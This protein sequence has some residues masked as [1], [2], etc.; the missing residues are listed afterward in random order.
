MMGTRG[1]NLWRTISA[2]RPASEQWHE[3]AVHRLDRLTMPH[4]ALGRLMDLAADLA[5]MTETLNPPVARRSIVAFAA[6]H[7]VWSQG[8]APY[9]QIVT[10]QVTR[11]IAG[12]VAS[13]CVLGRQ[14]GAQV[15][16]VDVGVLGDL[17]GIDETHLFRRKIARGT[18]DLS[19][20]P[21][22]TRD[23]AIQSLETG[24]EIGNLLADR[25]DIFGTGEMGVC[26]TTPSSAILSVMLGISPA[27]ATGPGSGLDPAGTAHKAE[28][29][30]RALK[31][32]N[33]DKND[34]IDVL[35]KVGGF[36]I[37]GIAGLILAAACQRKPVLLDGFIAAAA[38]VLAQ[39]LCPVCCDFMIASHRSSE[40][41]A[42]AALTKLGKEPLL[43]LGLHLGEGSG[44]ALAMHIV[45]AASLVITA[46][47]TFEESGVAEKI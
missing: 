11:N 23:Q 18:A 20:G 43:D 10:D 38:A 8:V 36:E 17:E 41:A 21:A 45:E 42:Q 6:D 15:Y 39:A 33:P 29:I 5:A 4:W 46:L 13:V 14:A 30:S 47:P 27:A 16:A 34:P 28:V 24:I 3:K 31:V 35:S 26:N 40:H 44:T 19:Q 25:T 2:I 32:N 9:P 7:G 1:E 22:M 37:G 12:G